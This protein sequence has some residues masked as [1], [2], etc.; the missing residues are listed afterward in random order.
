MLR[1][2]TWGVVV[3]GLAA[4]KQRPPPPVLAP[5]LAPAVAAPAVDAGREVALDLPPPLE[6]AGLPQE[7][8]VDDGAVEGEGLIKLLL[9]DPARAAAALQEIPTPDGWQVALLARLAPRRAGHAERTPEPPL[10]ELRPARAGEV[11]AGAKAWVGR[12]SLPLRP[13]PKQPGAPLELPLDTAVQLEAL[14]GG[15]ATVSVEVATQVDYGAAGSEPEAL[16]TELRRGVVDA[17]WL[18]PAPLEPRALLG[19]AQARLK[20]GGEANADAAV[21]LYRRALLIERS[22]RAREGLLRAGWAA[23]RASVVVEAA[24]AR[25]LAP[26]AGL[27]LAWACRGELAKA[28]WVGAAPKLKLAADA[29]VTGVDAR[30]P[31]AYAPA[32]KK[33]GWAALKAWR[34]AAGLAESPRLRFTVDARAPRLVLLADTT[35]AVRDECSDFEE[36]RL[37]GGNATV[38]RLLLPLGVAKTVV[39]VAVPR[40]HGAEYAVVAAGNELKA[41]AWLRARGNYAWTAGARGGLEVSLGVGDRGFTLE[42][43]VT[44]ATVRERPEL[45]CGCR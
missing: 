8:S 29:C 1:L 42:K 24:L 22:A 20:A 44:A 36:L 12:E 27:E 45:E 28:T 37:D 23:K 39:R 19:E 17:R 30:A 38:R 14:D 10:P 25:L 34:D 6:E 13:L 15:S 43:D 31:C 9:R 7:L 26:A 4:C 32:K 18:L 16:V 5:K 35:L 21:V 2:L 41:A 40:Y 33:K 11:Q 3:A